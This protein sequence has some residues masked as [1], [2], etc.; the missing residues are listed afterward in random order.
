METRRNATLDYLKFISAVLVVYLHIALKAD[1]LQTI[2]SIF[3]KAVWI[4]SPVEIFILITA[5]YFFKS[6]YD[7]KKKQFDDHA[8]AKGLKRYVDLYIAWTVIN[9]P[10]AVLNTSNSGFLIC[11]FRILRGVFFSGVVGPLWYMLGIIYGLLLIK[12]LL[13][14]TGEKG[15]LCISFGLFVL[16]LT[17]GS[18]YHLLD[19]ISLIQKMIDLTLKVTVNFYLLRVPVFLMI[20]YFLAKYKAD[21]RL[22]AFA[23]RQKLLMICL[24]GAAAALLFIERDYAV[25]N[26][27][28]RE[29]PAFIFGIVSASL[30]FSCALMI[31]IKG[32]GVSSFLG[33]SSAIIYF[34]HYETKI[35]ST[36]LFGVSDS[37]ILWLAA[38]IIGMVLTAVL[39]RY[40]DQYKALSYLI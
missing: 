29:Y 23:F 8:F 22:M 12:T 17:G 2:N 37:W 39:L 26:N 1:G 38:I 24:F 20:G 32:T 36:F 21:Q 31:Y 30:L 6:T 19:G 4:V 16:S 11:I 33:K 13:A 27:L 15:G 34:T 40:K 7:F 28:G 25:S 9:L 3:R 14:K 18:Y 5:F 10:A 35:L